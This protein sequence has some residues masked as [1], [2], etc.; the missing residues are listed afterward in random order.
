MGAVTAVRMGFEPMTSAV[1]GQ[2]SNQAKLTHH[3]PFINPI[4]IIF[5]LQP[6]NPHVVLTRIV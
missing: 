2:H 6:D 5:I 3:T 4:L 1:T